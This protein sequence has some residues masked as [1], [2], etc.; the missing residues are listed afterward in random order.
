MTGIAIRDLTRRFGDRTVLDEVSLEI[1]CGEVF[2]LSGPNGGGKTTL[3]ET[4]ATLLT[5][6]SGTA[7]VHGL[8]VVGQPD[9]V[10]AL[11]GSAPSSLHTFYPR[12]T[13]SANLQ[14]FAALKGLTAR[15]GR[16]QGET[17]LR[18]MGLKDA[19]RTRVDRYS[20]GMRARLSLAR[21]L[22]GDPPVLLLDEPMRS[23]D[24][25]S[26]A[27]IRRLLTRA[28]ANGDPRTILWITHDPQ[29]AAEVGHRGGEVH[30]G[31]LRGIGRS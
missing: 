21:A 9:R 17:L 24:H 23:I 13:G 19:A 6:S 15:E 31:R 2:T 5:P 22:L 8:D 10:R 29:E 14:F 18:R 20:D 4:L 25:Q 30:A 1:R 28:R 7:S 3:L 12:L 27:E 11:I 26:R 16:T